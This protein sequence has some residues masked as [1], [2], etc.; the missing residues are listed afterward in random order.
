MELCNISVIKYLLEK[1]GFRFSKAMGQ[2][3]LTADWVP[4]R[5]VE[6]S[7]I[8]K[9]C[10]VLEI[11]PGVGCLTQRLGEN[12]AK[13]VSVELDKRLIPLLAESL[14]EYDNIKIIN[15]DILDTDIKTVFE[16]N[17][18]GLSCHAC[19]NLPYNIT[20]PVLSKLIESGCFDSITVMIQ[21]EVARRICAK[22]G[23]ADYGA[24]T[25]YVNYYMQPEILFD[26]SPGC[27]MPPPKV[28]S[29]VIT[30]KKRAVP[31]VEVKDEALLFKVIKA[32]FGQRRKTLANA[33]S[34]GFSSLFSKDEITGIIKSCGFDERIRGEALDLAQFASIADA[35]W[36]LKNE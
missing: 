3:F 22:A 6:E 25:L 9:T 23:T 24:F 32:S 7:G 30:M 16:E 19:A 12:A 33:L 20:T 5:I 35:I 10:G 21:R 14:G 28:T 11:G 34:G 18:K 31:P 17:F 1:Y 36:S 13:V 27:F 8:D 26:V 2:N 15:G 4:R 29:S